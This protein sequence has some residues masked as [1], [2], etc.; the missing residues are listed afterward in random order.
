VKELDL[1][2]VEEKERT[3]GGGESGKIRDVIAEWGE[4]SC[5]REGVRERGGEGA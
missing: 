5:S 4:S 2:K 3:E 1:E